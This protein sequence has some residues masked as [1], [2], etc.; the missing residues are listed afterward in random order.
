MELR[1][2]DEEG[3]PHIFTADS[4]GMEDAKAA[5][6]QAALG[7]LHQLGA[8]V[9]SL[10]KSSEVLPDGPKVQE[11]TAM[12]DLLSLAFVLRAVPASCVVEGAVMAA[13]EVKAALSN[14]IALSAW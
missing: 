12:G 3:Q 9:G 4:K 6:Q 11:P 10:F 2:P 5:K 7:L 8:L 13:L 14:P 1:V